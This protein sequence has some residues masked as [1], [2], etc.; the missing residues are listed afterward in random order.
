[1]ALVLTEE[2]QM[3][4]DSAEAFLAEQA[5]VSE[6]RRLRDANDEVGF[7]RELWR[8]MA[9]MGFAGVLVPE[10][11]GGLGLGHVAAGVIQEAIGRNLSLSPFLSTA[12]LGATPNGC[13]DTAGFNACCDAAFIE[14]KGIPSVIFGPGDLRFAHSMDEFVNLSEV[15]AAARIL[16]RSAAR[17]C[18]VA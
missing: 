1:M 11:Q 9:E 13:A 4:R 8:A 5:P 10:A 18:G 17:W 15:A 2:Q 16:A 7:S 3:I 14:A 6:L 12:V